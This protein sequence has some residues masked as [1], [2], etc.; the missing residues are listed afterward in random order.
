MKKI[1]L[2]IVSFLFFTS[3]YSQTLLEDFESSPATYSLVADQGLTSATVVSDP[4]TNGTR[5]NVLEIITST[6]GQ[7]W[8]NAQATL[9][10][11]ID[12]TTSEKRVSVDIYST[13]AFVML[14]KVDETGLTPSASE[15][16]HTGTGWETLTFDFT[17]GADNT[18]TASDAVYARLLFFPLKK[19]NDGFEA[20]AVTTTYVDNI[21]SLYV[22]PTGAS[23]ATLSTITSGGVEITG[24]ISTTTDYTIGL[25]PGSVVGDIPVLAATTTEGTSTAVI[26]P[27]TTLPGSATITVTSSDATEKIYTISYI[28]SGDPSTSADAPTEASADVISVYSGAYATNI[29][30]DTNPNWGQATQVS[31]IVIDGSDPADN[32]LKYANL[33]YQGMG[34]AT[35]DVSGMEY[36]HLDYYTTDATALNFYLIG[37]GE[38]AYDLA[39]SSEFALG[40]WVSVDIPLTHFTAVNLAVVNQFKTNGN[41]TVYLDNLYFWKNP[42]A[43][44]SDATLSTITSG[45]VEITGFSSATTDYTIGL[46]PGSVAGDIPVLAATTTQGTSTAVI[47]PATTLPGSATIT[48]TSSDATEKIYT[49]FYAEETPST[50]APTPTEASAD[51]I[52]VYSDAYATNIVTDTNPNW[53]Q[54]TQVTEYAFSLEDNFLKYAN[55]DYQGMLL[56]TTDVSSMEY[57]HLDYYTID[58]TLLQFFLVAGGETAYDIKDTDGITLGQWVSIDIP[59]THFAARDLTTLIQAKTVGNG[60]V[61]LDN[62]YFWKEPTVAGSDTTVSDLTLDG[63]TIEG[64][65]SG[66]SNY[67]IELASNTTVVPTVA[68]TTTDSNATAVVT[69]AA[70]IPGTT[71]ILVTAADGITNNTI[72]INFTLGMPSAPTPTVASADVI[73]V[74]SDAYATNIVTDTN[75]NWGQGTTVS[76]PSIV[77]SDPVDYVLKYA[78]LN[79]QGLLYPSTDVS[80]ME[81][82]HLDYY[83]TDATAF[84]FFLVAGG[85][86]SYNIATDGGGITLGQW[87]SID[88]PMTHFAARDLTA[89]IQFKTVGNGTLYLDNL[90]FWKNPSWIGT[91][92][93]FTN[94]SNW[95]SGVVP[96]ASS[97]ITI[98]SDAELNITG[99][100]T[101][102][103]M[104]IA[105]GAS[106]ISDGSITGT[107]SYTRSIPTDN[108]YLISSPVVGQDKDAFVTAS[109]FAT[110]GSNVGFADY[111]NTSEAWSYYQSGTSG[112]GAFTQGQGHSVKL[113]TAGDV[114]FTGT[115]NDA[116]ASIGVTNNAN[117]FNLIGNPYLASVS[118]SELLNNNGSLLSESTVWLWDQSSSSYVQKNLAADLEIA[119]GQ[120]FFISAN[121]SGDFGIT[122]SMQSHSADTFQRTVAK[123]EVE[124]SLSNGKASRTAS[125]YYIDGATTGFDNGYDSSIFGGFDNDFSLYTHAVA[126]GTGRNL[127]IQSLPK[128]EY[129]NMIIPVGVIAESGSSLEFSASSE[130]LPEGIKIY[131]EDRQ[132]NTFIRLD[133]LNASYKLTTESAINGVG[134]FYLHTNQSVLNIND[135]TLDNVSVFRVNNSLRIV[136]LQQGRASVKLFNVLGRQV[137][138]TAFESNGTK[139]ISLPSLAKGVYIVHLETVEGALNKKIILE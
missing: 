105:A 85:E 59:M 26:S 6:T 70:S 11:A 76:T 122:E 40:Q 55:L 80:S 98:P 120:A 116:D 65:S 87:V 8:Q 92:G 54:G 119:P 113:A 82:L 67:D 52:S 62:I 100:I 68:A 99:D 126:N 42:S 16:S 45:G 136:G 109:G 117:G 102:N 131:L 2:L 78:N 115:F 75:P 5:G 30:T 124:L 14:A 38:T 112:S 97:D 94:A 123:P 69:D 104:S 72:T 137:L 111:N 84:E 35:T 90:Y 108:W 46:A 39:G 66:V 96:G 114:V 61:Y 22:A 36:L 125:I 25:A 89:A 7:P 43:G 28:I 107:V 79:Y 81:Y 21:T 88:I 20:V 63:V 29:V 34:Y 106:I 138:N 27:A 12:L 139:D 86:N 83:T 53:G 91:D 74:Y 37:G 51:V 77:G 3:G 47:S 41:G 23:D 101:V 1:T 135:V 133:A 129:Q 9:T 50:S 32:V 64:F 10:S 103:S 13:S 48:V 95:S 33:N 44:A 18:A 58:A 57:L 127:G 73:S 24:F 56:A 118:V 4:E 71:S 121:T 134:R 110:S 128:A 132:E 17:D 19:L 130:N 49:I 60:T 15:K 31:E 93:D